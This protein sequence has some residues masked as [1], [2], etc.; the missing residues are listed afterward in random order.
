ME[1]KRPGAA[2]E[3][4]IDCHSKLS[5]RALAFPRRVLMDCFW[6]KCGHNGHVE[7]ED[8]PIL[9]F[10]SQLPKG[11][12]HVTHV[13]SVWWLH[14]SS[15]IFGS[16]VTWISIEVILHRSGFQQM[17][18]AWTVELGLFRT[19]FPGLP[20]SMASRQWELRLWGHGTVKMAGMIGF[21]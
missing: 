12:C 4:G 9:S 16:T 20:T 3:A 18:L 13:G 10:W 21:F 1:G 19:T 11:S 2:V 6:R 8:C 14:H 15:D 17:D 5:V 7:N